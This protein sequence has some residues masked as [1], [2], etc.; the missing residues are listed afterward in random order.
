VQDVCDRITILF[1]GKMQTIGQVKDLLQVRDVTQIEARGMD[2]P[3]IAELR[4]TLAGMGLK[5]TTITHPT[6]TLEDLFMR[7][8]REN[9]PNNN[10]QPVSYTGSPESR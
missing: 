7:I 10:G 1:R 8:I 6:T 5:D 3:Q 2:E 4:R 9:T